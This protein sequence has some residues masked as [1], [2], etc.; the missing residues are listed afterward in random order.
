MEKQIS[1]WSYRLGLLSTVVTLAMRGL[2]WIGFTGSFGS[3]KGVAIGYNSFLHGAILFL[4]LS[5]AA[6]LVSGQAK[7]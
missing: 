1:V 3:A 4:L 6:S 5:A 2:A 7:S